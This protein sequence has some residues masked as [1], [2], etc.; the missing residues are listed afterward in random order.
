MTLSSDPTPTQPLPSE[1]ILVAA[2]G[3]LGLHPLARYA[4]KFATQGSALHLAAVTG[5]PRLLFPTIALQAEDW[6]DAHEAVL[7][8]SKA[9]LA[10]AERRLAETPRSVDTSVVDLSAHSLSPAQAVASLACRSNASLVAITAFGRG[11]RARGM[12]RIDPEELA[13]ASACPVL[14]VPYACLEDGHTGLDKVMIGLDGSDNS[15][16]ALSFVMSHVP[17]ATRIHV[18]HVVDHA[19]GLRNTPRIT[20]LMRSGMRILKRAYDMLIQCGRMGETTLLGT[21]TSARTVAETIAHEADRWNADLVVLG[22]R[23]H[24]PFRR[25]LLGSVSERSLRSARRAVLIVPA[26][27]DRATLRGLCDT[28]GQDRDAVAENSAILPPPVF[29]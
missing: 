1:S 29:L 25:W 4:L 3:G 22:T 15:F 6:L 24:S 17:A 28:L 11:E 26:L 9:A 20:G 21:S 5:D 23:G 19:L 7:S 27:D 16:E 18:V 2:E 13:S 14:Y 12:W 10:S 8:S